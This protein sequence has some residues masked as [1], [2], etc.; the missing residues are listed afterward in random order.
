MNHQE[1]FHEFR[2]YYSDPTLSVLTVLLA[3]LLFVAAPLQA[4]L[5]FSF[6]PLGVAIILVMGAG[7]YILSGR[8]IILIPLA[9][10]AVLRFALTLRREVQDLQHSHVYLIASLWLTL[11][12]TFAVVVARAVYAAGTITVHRIVGAILVYLLISLVFASLYLFVGATFPGAF[13]NL[14]I[15]DTPELGA[16]VIYFSLT[17]LTSVGFGDIT[18]VHPI[19][20]SL[21]NLESICGQLYPAILL[22]RLVSLHLEQT[23]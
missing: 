23:K 7:V 22:A 4:T 14:T 8:W 20:R 13:D 18:P 6:L 3:L 5:G 12:V 15:A 17:T 1:K 10:A 19:A 9:I 11:S 16:N 2:K 21:C